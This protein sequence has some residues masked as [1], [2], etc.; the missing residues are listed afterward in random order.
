MLGCP[1]PMVAAQQRPPQP[2]SARSRLELD[3]VE[4][5]TVGQQLGL[6]AAR[7]TT[8]PSRVKAQEVLGP[9]SLSE[10][11]TTGYSPLGPTAC[12]RPPSTHHL[13]PPQARL[14]QDAAECWRLHAPFFLRPALS[15]PRPRASRP[16][17]QWTVRQWRA[18]APC[19]HDTRPPAPSPPESHG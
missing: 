17:G 10:T 4:S 18:T 3:A 11:R 7:A 16:P 5:S 8:Q 13:C 19:T 12:R 9:L 15:L 1:R 14:K 6:P 2:Q